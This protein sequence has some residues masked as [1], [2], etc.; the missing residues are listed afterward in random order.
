MRRLT[1][2]FVGISVM[3]ALVACGSNTASDK[4]KSTVSGTFAPAAPAPGMLD[5]R[6][7]PVGKNAPDVVTDR[8]EVITGTVDITAEHPID[9]AQQIADRVRD[10]GGRVDS[11]TEQP[12]ADDKPAQATLT[13]RVPADQT[14]KF[15][16]GLDGVGKVTKVSTNRDDVT[17]RW[18]DL[19]A[20][21]KALQASVDRLRGLIAG[22]TNTADLI[23]AENALSGRQGELDSLTAQKKHLDDEIAL[24]TL[25]IEITSKAKS[26]GA[27]NF[28]DGIVSGWHSLVNWLKDAVVFTGKAIPWLGFLGVLAALVLAIVR[29]VRRWRGKSRSGQSA[30]EKPEV[31][32]QAVPAGA[33]ETGEAGAA[34]GSAGNDQTEQP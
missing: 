25:T 16:T 3:A 26:S 23:A 11:R 28:G 20:R 32:K 29:G 18:E 6:S 33:S 22:A 30:V 17:M 31:A 7:G 15:I 21:I 14:D 9:A 27:D 1:V 8:K 4:P 24:S 12:G 2:I 5:Q 19:D 10:A 13:V 34:D